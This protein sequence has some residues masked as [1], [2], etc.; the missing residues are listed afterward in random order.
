[1]S[2]VLVLFDSGYGMTEALAREVCHGV[3]TFALRIEGASGTLAYTADSAYCDELVEAATGADVLLAEATL[4]A[5]FAG[6][7]PHMTGTEAGRVFTTLARVRAPPQAV[8]RD[9]QRLGQTLAHGDHAFIGS[10]HQGRT[11]LNG[12]TVTAA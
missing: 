11:F 5:V 12:L 2:D 4:P 7:A 8:H 9:G 10:H 3:E 6:A 1:M